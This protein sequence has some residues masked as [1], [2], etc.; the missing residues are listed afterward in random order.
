MASTSPHRANTLLFHCHDLGNYLPCYGRPTVRTPHIDRLAGEGVL[1][2]RCFCAAPQCSPARASLFTGRY[3]HANGVMGLC[4][5]RFA[6]DLHPDE[7]HLGQ[8]LAAAG[9]RT[10]GVGVLHE[11]HSGP[12][13]CGLQRYESEHMV[14]DAVSRTIALVDQVASADAPFYIQAGCV[15]PRRL[16]TRGQL[17]Q[18]FLGDHLQPDS[19]AGADVPGFLVDDDAARQEIAELQGAIRHVDEHF[20]RLLAHLDQS[21]WRDHTVVIFTADHGVALPRA[22]C[23]VYE[24]GLAVGFLVRLPSRPGWT[25]GRRLRE[26]ISQVDV[27][28]T[29]LELAGQSAPA[30]VQGRSFAA[31]VDGRPYTP[32][33]A[34]FGEMTCHEYYDPV[35]SVRTERYK[36]IRNCSTAP[37]FMDCPQS[38]RPRMLTRTPADPSA[39]YHSPLELYDLKADP[40]EQTDLARREELSGVRQELLGRLAAHLRATGDPLLAGP[41]A[42]PA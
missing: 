41:V 22:K 21:P 6:R 14:A 42:D 37:G 33:D 38:W 18:G 39:A 29:L 19:S 7:Q 11:T 31:L 36:L 9:C 2:E 28:P 40:L 17:R 12:T 20:G 16:R 35:R 26:M 15:E 30:N 23:M 32:R 25:G 3:P 24:P 13:R 34:V 10:A 5:D 1:L 8:L 4:H 27:L